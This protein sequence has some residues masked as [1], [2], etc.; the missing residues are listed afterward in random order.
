MNL[1]LLYYRA[2]KKGRKI[3][4][5]RVTP[6]SFPFFEQTLEEE[7][8]SF[9]DEETISKRRIFI[10]THTHLYRRKIVQR[11]ERKGK[12]GARSTNVTNVSLSELFQSRNKEKWKR[13]KAR[14]G[15]SPSYIRVS[16]SRARNYRDRPSPR[17]FVKA[18][19]IPVADLWHC[20][21]I[22]IYMKYV[23]IGCLP[24]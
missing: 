14:Q 23:Y 21:H 5:I 22:Y 15:R 16:L 11:G 13:G 8:S 18:V 7:S 9:V 2:E 4:V 1:G 17:Q 24:P 12:R 19:I 3:H 20:I 10:Y 6:A